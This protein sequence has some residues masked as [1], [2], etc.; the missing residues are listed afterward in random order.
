MSKLPAIF[1]SACI[2]MACSETNHEVNLQEKL[3]NDTT[4]GSEAVIFAAPQVLI[5]LQLLF[6]RWY[7]KRKRMAAAVIKARDKKLLTGI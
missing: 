6:I 1:L 7:F 5:V 2:F 3:K 4:G